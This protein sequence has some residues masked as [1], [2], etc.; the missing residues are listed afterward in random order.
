M[1]GPPNR[2][3]GQCV[4]YQQVRCLQRQSWSCRWPP[5]EARQGQEQRGGAVTGAVVGGPVGAVVGGVAGAAAGVVLTPDETVQAR[6]YVVTRRSP[7]SPPPRRCRRWL[8]ASS[9]CRC[10]SR[11]A[12][13]GPA[14][15]LRVCRR[16]RPAGCWSIQARGRW[17]I[18]LSDARF[19]VQKSRGPEARKSRLRCESDASV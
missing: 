15:E 2:R 18:S 16:Q 12:S 17:C 3:S 19:A 1:L 4:V 6:R 5:A 11:S 14:I 13:G 10:L 7:V 9:S 8:S